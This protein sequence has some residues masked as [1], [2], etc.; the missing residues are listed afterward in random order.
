VCVFFRRYIELRI[1]A[2][3]DEKGSTGMQVKVIAGTAEVFGH[4][5]ASKRNYTFVNKNI[6]VYTFHGCQVEVKGYHN[7]IIYVSDQTPMASY[8][9]THA[10]LEQLRKAAQRKGPDCAGPRVLVVGPTDVG[11]TTL[12]RILL[13]YAVRSGRKPTYVDLDVGQ[14]S[15]TIPGV[16]AATPYEHVMGIDSLSDFPLNAPMVY[17]FGHTTPS[18]NIKN[19][20][21]GMVQLEKAVSLRSEKSSEASNSGVII[22][23]C[24]WI[25]GDGYDL[26]VEA[27]GTFKADIILVLGHEKLYTQLKTDEK[28]Q[29]ITVAK[30]NKSSGVLERSAEQRSQAR[31]KKFHEYFYG[32]GGQLR[33]HQRVM[34]FRDLH[35]YEFGGGVQ[36]P[37]HTLPIGAERM[38]AFD[39][40]TPV[41]PSQQ[42][43]NVVLAVSY[44]KV[45]SVVV[46]LFLYDDI[47][48]N[49]MYSL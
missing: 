44:A 2:A 35:I 17:F 19:F 16:L 5:L 3:A 32:P 30:L 45:S 41:E 26:I 12:C 23:T 36:A 40:V 13:N 46:S 22:N 8:I 24:G 31:D 29:N 15:I 21:S 1:E 6:A 48:F 11:K 43:V 9:A 20:K 33:P 25:D 10:S 49:C 28:L 4:E 37:S 34:P 39:T 7:D 47:N 38:L 42:L 27:S 14:N 18:K